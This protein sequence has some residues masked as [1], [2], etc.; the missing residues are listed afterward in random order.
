[1]T[2]LDTLHTK[3][4][5]NELSFLLATHMSYFNTG[6]GRY[7]L[8]KSGYGTDQILDRLDRQVI[9]QV[10]RALEV[11]ILLGLEHGFRR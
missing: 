10:F 6:F 1:M 2:S 4:A 8:L 3:S 11:Q 9:D 7:G 5:V